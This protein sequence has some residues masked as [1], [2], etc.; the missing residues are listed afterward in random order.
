MARLVSAISSELREAGPCLEIGIG[1]GRFAIPLTRAGARIVGV[2]I[3]REMLARLA[4]NAGGLSIPVAI[5]DATRLPFGDHTFGAGIAAHVFHLIPRWTVALDELVRVIRPGG[6]IV[7]FARGRK[8]DGWVRDLHHCF[9]QAVG[10]PDW[11]PGMDTI[12]ELD[13]EMAA[14]GIDRRLVEVADEKRTFTVRRSIEYLEQGIY[15]AC[16]QLDE[17]TRR[18]AAQVATRWAE[19]NLGDFDEPR[20]VVEAMAWRVYDL[21]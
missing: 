21:P 13:A 1:T 3:S 14:R 19:A 4:R 15:S 17:E 11:P 10:D 5:G 20:V 7:A 9:F 2:D 16:W 6:Q 12:E 18:R 8:L